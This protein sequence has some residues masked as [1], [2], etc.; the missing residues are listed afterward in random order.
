MSQSRNDVESPGGG[1]RLPEEETRLSACLTSP[2]P[3]VRRH[4]A[5]RAGEEGDESLGDT[6]VTLLDDPEPAVRREAARALGRL[7]WGEAIPRLLELLE[8]ETPGVALDAAWALGCIGGP[9]G[10]GLAEEE[11]EPPGRARWAAPAERP[12]RGEAAPRTS[13][14]V[15]LEALAL[16]AFLGFGLGRFLPPLKA[17]LGM[18]EAPVALDGSRRGRDRARSLLFPGEDVLSRIGVGASLALEQDPRG[19]N[20]LSRAIDDFLFP[21]GT[22]AP[23]NLRLPEDVVASPGELVEDPWPE[24]ELR[25]PPRS[26]APSSSLPGRNGGRSVSAVSEAPQD[27]EPALEVPGGPEPA[28]GPPLDPGPGSP[29]PGAAS[30]PSSEE[31]IPEGFGSLAGVEQEL[32]REAALRYLRA[33][34]REQAREL[35]SMAT[36]RP[37]ADQDLDRLLT[38]ESEGNDRSSR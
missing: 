12:P 24:E 31:P 25:W 6:L 30:T 36:G 1:S 16:V 28:S 21:S 35:L 10:D 32:Y 37:V 22:A 29:A 26:G 20:L 17:F 11:P 2:F 18:E 38:P 15:G 19:L 27:P 14:L 4:G 5:R 34:D 13:R 9:E 7:D 8:D 33:G 23:R 3:E